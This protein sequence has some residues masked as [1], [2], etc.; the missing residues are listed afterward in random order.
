MAVNRAEHSQESFIDL[1]VFRK[2][3]L[4]CD[5]IEDLLVYVSFLSFNHLMLLHLADH[6]LVDCRVCLKVFKHFSCIIMLL[7]CLL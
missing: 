1:Y 6:F 3:E 5:F 4:G 2:F 7:H